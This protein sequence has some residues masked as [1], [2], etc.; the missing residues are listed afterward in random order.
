MFLSSFMFTLSPQQMKRRRQWCTST[1]L[2]LRF[3]MRGNKDFWEISI[4][5]GCLGG[6]L[7]VIGIIDVISDILGEKK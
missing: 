6:V 2:V 4:I 5:F 1:H 3:S 7:C